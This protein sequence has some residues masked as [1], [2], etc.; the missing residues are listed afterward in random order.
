MVK[1]KVSGQTIAIIILSVMLIS[2]IAFGGVYAFYTTRS[3]RVSGT[4]TMARLNIY[5]DGGSDKLDPSGISALVI[6]NKDNIVP[7]QSLGNSPLT[8]MNW[9]T[10]NV[11]LVVAYKIEATKDNVKVVD[12]HK[13]PVLGLGIEYIN[14]IFKSSSTN[15]EYD[16]S[17]PSNAQWI[18]YVF[19]SS[20]DKDEYASD[21]QLDDQNM[22]KGYRCLV[23]TVAFTPTQE[24]AEGIKAI[25]K[26]ALAL[27]RF[28][29]NGYQSSSLTLTFQAYA[30]AEES[31]NSQVTNLTSKEEKC[32]IIVSS[33]YESQDSQFLKG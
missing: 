24:G 33:I 26:D 27:S 7:G 3:N 25:G 4:I 13:E 5:M 9:S 10:V 32:E 28:M 11:Y 20:N 12:K 29:G 16:S 17:D 14:S 2:A 31:I 6:T 30:I 15:K 21:I 19:R 23:S 18:D 1:R 22:C 8:I